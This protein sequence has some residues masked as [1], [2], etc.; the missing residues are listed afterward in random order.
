MKGLE[1]EIG[2]EGLGRVGEEETGG[3]GEGEAEME[4][5]RGCGRG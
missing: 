1:V 3:G 5:G 2:V 4:E